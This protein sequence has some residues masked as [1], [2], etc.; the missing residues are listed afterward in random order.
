MLTKDD[1]EAIGNIVDT[2][3]DSK[4]TS[5]FDAFEKKMDSKITI[6][7]EMFE[8]TIDKKLNQKF[9]DFFENVLVPYFDGHVERKLDDHEKRISDLEE[10]QMRS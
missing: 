3:V 10:V 6:A 8:K 7:F 2:K 4:I 9:S 1:L 5:A